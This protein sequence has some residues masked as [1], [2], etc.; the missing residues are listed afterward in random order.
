MLAAAAALVAHIAD[1]RLLLPATQMLLTATQI[2]NEECE[3]RRE[4]RRKATSVGHLS[5]MHRRAH[6][7]ISDYALYYERQWE[8]QSERVQAFGA[9]LVCA[10]LRCKLIPVSFTLR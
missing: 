1:R 5:D 7:G 4:R 10:N 9:R 3:E 6:P 8:R 2:S